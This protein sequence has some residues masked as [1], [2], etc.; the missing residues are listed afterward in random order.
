M[1]VFKNGSSGMLEKSFSGV[2]FA[3][4]TLPQST[5]FL[6]A[7]A[8][9]AILL[10]G[11]ERSISKDEMLEGMSQESRNAMN[12]MANTPFIVEGVATPE[13]VSAGEAHLRDAERIIGIVLNGQPR[14]Y[15]LTRLSAMIDHVVNDHS[16]NSDGKKLLFSVT[17]CDM[18]DCVRVLEPTA[19]TTE[20]SLGIRTLGIL[21]S[22]L[23]LQWKGKD[24]TQLDAVE[25]LRDVPYQRKSWGE[26]KAE[27]P[28]TMVYKG[29]ARQKGF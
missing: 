15:P 16:I 27:F 18:T 12:S 8:S 7:F 24:F 22:G 10:S 6:T 9:F 14:A 1:H 11:C 29:R 4:R 28:D 2:V 3:C 26:W 5:A 25:G 13:F 23:A 20:E 17:Y 19:E 21:D